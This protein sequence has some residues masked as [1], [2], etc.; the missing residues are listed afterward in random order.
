MA[1]FGWC[2]IPIELMPLPESNRLRNMLA[3]LVVVS[4][5]VAMTLAVFEFVVVRYFFMIDSEIG[6]RIYLGLILASLVL[7]IA[8]LYA[9][10][11]VAMWLADG[12]WPTYAQRLPTVR[13]LLT[14][15]GAAVWFVLGA[16]AAGQWNEIGPLAIPGSMLLVAAYCGAIGAA[17]VVGLR[18]MHR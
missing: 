15:F 16:T 17:T 18:R 1:Q 5:F 4:G 12:E 9:L 14:G 13:Q 7:L 10:L 6:G 2:V 11:Q 3:F 8:P